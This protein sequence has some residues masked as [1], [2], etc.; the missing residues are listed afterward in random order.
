M[1]KMPDISIIVPTYNEER[2]IFDCLSSILT[3]K[4]KRRYEVI[5]VDN[6]SKD[7]T[8]EIVAK[9]DV[10][11]VWESKP[12]ASAAR[13]TG[14]KLARANI[15]YFVDAD[16]RLPQGQ[17]EKIY[18]AFIDKKVNVVAGPYIYDMDGF[19]P[20]LVT[21]N[22]KYFYLYHSLIRLIFG[23]N[24]FPGGNFAIR[25]DLFQKVHGFDETICNQ[26]IV[27]P[28]DL[29]LAIKL[30]NWGINDVLFDNKYKIYSSFRRVKKSPIKHTLIRFFAT[31]SML[32]SNKAK[33]KR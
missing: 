4:T 15:L 29:D 1:E 2:Y 32:Y 28:D 31:M 25:K 3:Q 26:E 22:M 24:T 30:H 6:N 14:A 18:Q 33:T 27:L 11:L 8:K 5:V 16:C 12:G 17:I 20:H 10:R 9:F 19:I 21:G 23:I 13:N 7:A